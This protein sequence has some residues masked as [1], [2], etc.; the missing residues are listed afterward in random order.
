MEA[1]R[2]IIEAHHKVSLPLDWFPRQFTTLAVAR[3]HA[4]DLRR[5]GATAT[6]HRVGPKGH[7]VRIVQ[8]VKVRLIKQTP[9]CAKCKSPDIAVPAFVCW[10]PAVQDWLITNVED[11]GNCGTCG[12]GEVPI[13][14]INPEPTS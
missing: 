12:A 3:W 10:S 14:W 5:R 9:V 4:R 1:P 13:D 7:E 2:R 6:L 11:F 8:D